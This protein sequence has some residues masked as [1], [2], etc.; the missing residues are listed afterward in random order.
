M[1]SKVDVP[2]LEKY[3]LERET[4]R[5]SGAIG[6]FPTFSCPPEFK[7]MAIELDEAP[8]VSLELFKSSPISKTLERLDLLKDD[9]YAYLN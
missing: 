1:D 9:R 2:G 6:E 8:L 3:E 7:G 5:V 4:E